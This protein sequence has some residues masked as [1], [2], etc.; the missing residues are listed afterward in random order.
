MHISCNHVTLSQ[1]LFLVV[2]APSAV[3][4]THTMQK[5]HRPSSPQI[6]PVR[7]Q[8]S[9]STT[10]HCIHACRR[11]RRAGHNEAH[12]DKR[13]YARAASLNCSI[14]RSQMICRIVNTSVYHIQGWCRP[15]DCAA[16]AAAAECNSGDVRRC[17][18]QH[19][20]AYVHVLVN[21]AGR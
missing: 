16:A 13:K 11:Q 8:L 12:L 21:A 6:P 7:H 3:S 10:F 14:A 19:C 1:K 9:A 18:K 17:L 15:H 5:R 4:D 20:Y 2:Y